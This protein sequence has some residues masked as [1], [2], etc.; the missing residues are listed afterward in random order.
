MTKENWL[1]FF[2]QKDIILKG[3]YRIEDSALLDDHD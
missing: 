1:F 3:C 2:R